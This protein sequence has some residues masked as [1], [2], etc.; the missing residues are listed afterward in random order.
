MSASPPKPL[1]DSYWVIP[2]KLLAGKYPGAKK[3]QDLE[4]RLG[5]ILDAGFNAFIDLTE[6]GEMPPYEAYL[7]DGVVYRR[8]PVGDHGVMRRTWAKSSPSSRSCSTPVTACT[9]T[10]APASGAPAPPWPAT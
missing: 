10:A 4:R 1:A 6:S 3:L 7:P 8:K 9:C 5:P 2:G